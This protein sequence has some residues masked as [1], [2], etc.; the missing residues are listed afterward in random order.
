MGVFGGIL[1]TTCWK[2]GK[3]CKLMSPYEKKKKRNRKKREKQK[4]KEKKFLEDSCLKNYVLK[5]SWNFLLLMGCHG[6]IRGKK[7][8]VFERSRL[9]DE[10]D[11]LS[12]G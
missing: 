8:V 6:C 9:G 3:D 10:C 12:I 5:N 2:I 11:V 4:K 7:C 1:E